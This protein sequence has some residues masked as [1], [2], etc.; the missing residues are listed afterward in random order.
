MLCLYMQAKQQ[1]AERNC[2]EDRTQALLEW[3]KV[4][5][6]K[7]STA[8]CPISTFLVHNGVSVPRVKQ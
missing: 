1:V 4:R 5:K 2:R 7:P 6:Q 8:A 3:H